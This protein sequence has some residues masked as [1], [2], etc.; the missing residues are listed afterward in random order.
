MSA[1]ANILNVYL[2]LVECYER[3]GQPQMRDRFLILA[4]DAARSQGRKHDAELLRQRLL[5][6]NPHH[7]LKPYSTFDQALQTPDVQTYVRDL[8][9]NY[10]QE[11]VEDLLANLQ[12]NDD[13]YPRAV[14]GTNPE[15]D[16]PAPEAAS[17][18][19]AS[20]NG[21]FSDPEPWTS[22]APPAEPPPAPRP[23]T[24]VPPAPAKPRS[25]PPVGSPEPR[26]PAPAPAPRPQTSLPVTAQ[27]VPVVRP[28]PLRPEQ[29]AVP[30]QSPTRPVARPPAPAV[31]YHD[32]SAELAGNRD[33]ASARTPSG[34]PGAWFS[35]T[36]FVLVLGAG[37]FLAAF[38][39]ARPFLPE[40]WLR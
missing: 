10:P 34:A 2:G 19:P 9:Q 16:L 3:R 31:R 21:H 37:L 24:Q 12:E 32:P 11:V 30:G 40:A 5:Q 1:P 23:A 17:P 6:A 22:N 18:G 7:M 27:A 39:L 33:L 26:K 14:P 29:A 20:H 25:C 8:R 35:S 15:I 4:A 28:R 13:I 38:A 36:L